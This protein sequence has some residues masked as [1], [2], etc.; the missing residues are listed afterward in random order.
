MWL[1]WFLACCLA[2][3]HEDD[4]DGDDGGNSKALKRKVKKFKRHELRTELE[5]LGI[6]LDEDRDQKQR[7]SRKKMKRE[8]QNL[9]LAELRK[10]ELDKMKGLTFPMNI[11]DD[12]NDVLSDLDARLSR[13]LEDLQ[14]KEREDDV[15]SV[16]D[17]LLDSVDSTL[18]LTVAC[19]ENHNKEVDVD[20]M[21]TDDVAG[22][23]VVDHQAEK[24]KTERKGDGGQM[25]SAH[26]ARPVDLKLQGEKEVLGSSQARDRQLET[27][28]QVPVC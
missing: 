13:E 16:V 7:K 14:N 19:V 10:A 2:A 9:L 25:E 6:S 24:A 21:A 17:Y 11:S 8:L 4:G 23:T 3:R 20:K 12:V 28:G 5:L 15:Q 22:S 1:F 18:G 27:A 26:R